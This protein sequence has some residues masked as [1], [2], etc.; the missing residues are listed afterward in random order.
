MSSGCGLRDPHNA[1]LLSAEEVKQKLVEA[2]KAYVYEL[3]VAEGIQ[4]EIQTSQLSMLLAMYP[5]DG[6]PEAEKYKN[7]A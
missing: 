7:A 4:N 3:L 1:I 2:N 6:T 5:E